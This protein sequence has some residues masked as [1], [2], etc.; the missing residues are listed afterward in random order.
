MYETTTW[1]MF[2]PICKTGGTCG[3]AQRRRIFHSVFAFE[4]DLVMRWWFF[5]I[6]I[7]DLAPLLR[8]RYIVS[9]LARD[10]YISNNAATIRITLQMHHAWLWSANKLSDINQAAAKKIAHKNIT[11]GSSLN[12]LYCHMWHGHDLRPLR[13]SLFSCPTNYLLKSTSSPLF[14]KSISRVHTT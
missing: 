1:V 6:L 4:L 9:A 2:V 10:M 12:L 8:R 14:E 13:C 3:D 5:I 7:Y 11:H